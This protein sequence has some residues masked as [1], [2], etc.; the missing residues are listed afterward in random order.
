[1]KFRSLICSV[2]FLCLVSLT[3]DNL[4][5]AAAP[6]INQ[7]DGEQYRA[8]GRI[9]GLLDC[10]GFVIDTE[11][12]NNAP[13]YAVTNGHCLQNYAQSSITSDIVIGEDVRENGF[14][15]TLDF[16]HDSA[17]TLDLDITEIAY[18]TMKG[19]DLAIVRLDRDLI[20]LK[21]MGIQPLK[22]GNL[23]S[24]QESL[25]EVPG[26]PIFNGTGED[27]LRLDQCK[28]LGRSDL[29][30]WFWYWR[31]AIITDCEAIA[32]GNSG[33]PLIA[34]NGKVLGVINTSTAKASLSK[35]CYLGQACEVDEQGA[36]FVQGRSYAVPV[37]MLTSCFIRGK[38]D[39][40][41]EGCP[42]DP[43]SK[44]SVETAVRSPSSQASMEFLG[45]TWD[46]TMSGLTQGFFYKTGLI[47]DIDC[48]NGESYSEKIS[49][50]SKLLRDL[51]MPKQEGIYIMCIRFE[52]LE[53]KRAGQFPLVLPLVIDATGPT[54]RPSATVLRRGA[55]NLWFDPLFD[56]PELSGYQFKVISGGEQCDRSALNL[57]NR[58][59]ISV[60]IAELPIKVCLLSEDNV[61][62]AG[63]L[64]EFSID[65]VQGSGRYELT[66]ELVGG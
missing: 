33:S 15:L 12:N 29:L 42:L 4:A 55:D 65:S 7:S 50:R 45:E 64:W 22:I 21:Q 14:S 63:S 62:N 3:F 52:Q 11:Q 5:I 36:E 57:Y 23:L 43:G 26:A 60:S 1:M 58:I 20:E 40:E 61:G 16:F 66:P 35:T 18:A 51:D 28:I 56:V 24:T 41:A 30:E 10:T 31:D 44:I 6:L 8:I 32:E 25:I 38:F 39:I 48:F 2:V 59:P 13:A 46:I 54:Q 27:F 37:D 9:T 49:A 19:T 53:M 34:G 17:E 47:G